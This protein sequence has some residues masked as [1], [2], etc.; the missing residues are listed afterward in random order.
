[1]PAP[2]AT[3]RHAINRRLETVAIYVLTVFVIVTVLFLLPRFLPGDP[4][5]ALIDGDNNITMTAEAREQLAAHYGLDRPLIEQYVSY[6]GDVATFDF[7]W[8]ISFQTP[9]WDLIKSR[10]PWTALLMGTSL[11]FA[12]GIS[13][14]AG[15]WS[16]WRRGSKADRAAVTVLTAVRAVP[17]YAIATA[18]LITLAVLIPVFPVAG[19]RTLFL[20]DASLLERVGDVAAHLVLPATALT[21]GLMGSKFLLVRNTVIG[22]LGQEYMLLARAKGLPERRQQFG[23]AGRNALLPFLA[24]LGIQT[25]FA[26]G[27]AIFVETVFTY[28]GMGTLILSAV[29]ARDYPLLE[30][31]FVVLAGAILLANLA[32]DLISAGLYPATASSR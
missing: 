3:R 18:L 20:Q 23:H 12:S 27:G 31:L 17:E 13:F 6:L 21:L 19:G 22:T 7:G 14:I 25:G 16:G 9:V 10:G 26:V 5:A 8:S 29:E 4:L 32:I 24:I 1:M 2:P 15:V 30:A 11:L 28:P